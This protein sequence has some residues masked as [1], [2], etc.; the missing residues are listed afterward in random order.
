MELNKPELKQGV[1]E[2]LPE[3]PPLLEKHQEFTVWVLAKVRKFPKDLRYSFG[4]HL[5]QNSL[6]IMDLLTEALYIGKGGK[7]NAVL[8][9]ISIRIEQLRIQLRMAYNLKLIN[10][11]AL[12]YAVRCIKEEGSMLG[13]WMKA[14]R[15]YAGSESEQMSNKAGHYNG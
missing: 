3:L 6:F 1:R 4:S 10:G 14:G 5:A 2:K 15:R 7:R 12:H 11:G 8:Q 13:G 9:N